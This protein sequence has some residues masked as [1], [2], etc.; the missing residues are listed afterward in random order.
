VSIASWPFAAVRVNH[1]R[2]VPTGPAIAVDWPKKDSD[3]GS[4]LWKNRA[5]ALLKKRYPGGENRNPGSTSADFI[6]ARSFGG[7]VPSTAAAKI[8]PERFAPTRQNRK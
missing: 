3:L 2:G 1:Q 4:N 7:D 8:V 5:L 6:S